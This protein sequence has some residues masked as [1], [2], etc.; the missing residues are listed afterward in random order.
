MFRAAGVD[1]K[2]EAGRLYRF[3]LSRGEYAFT[4]AVSISHSGTDVMLGL[5]QGETRF[6][7]GA[8]MSHLR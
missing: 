5:L 7:G 4:G 3:A 1:A 8:R 2:A 6:T